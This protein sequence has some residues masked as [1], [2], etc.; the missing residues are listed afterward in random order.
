MTIFLL[1]FLT[2]LLK[3]PC[4]AYLYPY[5][6][7]VLNHTREMAEVH[8]F[9]GLE[10]IDCIY[11][12]NLDERVEKW[13]LTQETLN[14]HGLNPSRFSAINGWKFSKLIKRELFG[15]YQ[16]KL[17]GGQIG[18]LLSHLSVIQDAKKRGFSLVWIMEDDIDVLE[19]PKALENLIW[20]LSAHDPEWDILFTDQNCKDRQ[21]NAITYVEVVA[22][23]DQ[24]H[25]PLAYYRE[26]III[27]SQLEEIHQ[28]AGLYSYIVSERGIRKILDYFSHVYL[29]SPIDIDIFYIPGI[30]TYGTRREIISHQWQS[31]IS[32]TQSAPPKKRLSSY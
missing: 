29:W 31:P 7:P 2:V 27:N 14:H 22:R 30:K 1:L 15:P 12:I 18:C 6:T 26:R 24:P 21:G 13:K 32:D 8:D 11:V 16:V 3:D 23:P 10:L 17:I 5:Q 25:F 19:N 20:E 9:S 28:R 4:E